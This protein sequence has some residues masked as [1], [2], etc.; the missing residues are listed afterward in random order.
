MGTALTGV[1]IQNDYLDVCQMG[2]TGGGLTGTLQAVCDGSGTPS[3]LWLSTSAS[4]IGLGGTD[5]TLNRSA[6]GIIA[7]GANQWIQQSAGRSRVIT[8][9][10]TN[11]TASMTNVTGLVFT[12]KAGRTYTGTVSLKC[13]NST[14]AE[15]IQVDFGG[16]SATATAF[17]A[18]MIVCGGLTDTAGTVTSTSLAGVMNFTTLTGEQVVLIEYYFVCNVA[19]TIQVRAAENSHTSGTLTIR[20]GSNIWVEDTP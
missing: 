14:A 20:V 13:I 5:T 6:A 10:Y 19:G 17:W 8:S 3:G 7:P 12:A 11:A 16:G 4:A 15:G 9:D 18:G 1:K 2:N